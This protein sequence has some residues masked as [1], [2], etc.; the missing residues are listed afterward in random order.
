MIWKWWFVGL[1]CLIPVVLLAYWFTKESAW[2]IMTIVAVA[3]FGVFGIFFTGGA[4][5]YHINH[6]IR[7]WFNSA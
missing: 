1:W 4:I 7:N 2:D 5:L 3:I 6:R